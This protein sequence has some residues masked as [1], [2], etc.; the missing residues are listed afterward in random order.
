MLAE[1][2]VARLPG[3]AEA[4]NFGPP[5]HE[6]KSVECVVQGLCRLWP[7][8]AEWFVTT[9][10]QPHEATNLYLDSAKANSRLQWWPA[11]GLGEA[12]DLTCE[13]YVAYSKGEDVA[14]LTRD[15]IRRYLELPDAGGDV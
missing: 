1:R 9:E 2:L 6:A 14:A 13:W 8:K 12:L 3:F 10:P 11:L 5:Y 7:S 15:Q 4:W